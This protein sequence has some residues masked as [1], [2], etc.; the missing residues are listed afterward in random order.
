MELHTSFDNMEF[1]TNK[2]EIFYYLII[3]KN[4]YFDL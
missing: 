3:N 1:K 2:N 4:K